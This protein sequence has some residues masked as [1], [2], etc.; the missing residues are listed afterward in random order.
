MVDHD[1]REIANISSTLDRKRNIIR[2]RAST[3]W[4]PAEVTMIEVLTIALDSWIIQD[5]NYGEFQTGDVTTFAVEFWTHDRALELAGSD[6]AEPAIYHIAD[7]TY[8]IC[9]PIVYVAPDWWV[10]D[11]GIPV[12][13]NQVPPA[14]AIQGQWLQGDI[15]LRIDPFFYFERLSQSPG[16]PPLIFEWMVDA[17]DMQSAPFVEATPGIEARDPTRLGWKRIAQTNAWHDDNGRAEYLLHCKLR[18]Q[19]ASHSLTV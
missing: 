17:I 7:A 18:S 6:L 15:S 12:Y 8:K 11:I 16:S 5:G 3:S 1:K 2:A 9:A 14:G 10:I 19:A 4:E 13:Q